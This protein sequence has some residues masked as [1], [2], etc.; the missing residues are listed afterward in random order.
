MPANPYGMPEVFDIVV[1][2]GGPA[3][4]TLAGLLAQKNRSVLVLERE[5]FPRYHIGES[6]IPGFMRAMEE[7]GLSE[8]LEARGF[9]KKGGG[10]LRW[11]AN[12]IPWA[13]RFNEGS[14]YKYSYHV[15]RADLDS[16]ILDR[17]RELGAKV[18]EEATV[19]DVIEEDGR[20]AGVTYVVR[21]SEV[22][23]HEA[24]A[25][26]VIDASGQARV[27][28]RKFTTVNWHEELRNVAVWTYFDNC[29]RL[30]GEEYSNILI[31]GLS[32]G[33]FWGI[34]IGKSTMSVGFVTTSET[35]AASGSLEDLFSARREGSTQLRELL[36]DARQAGGFRTARDW[37]YTCDRFCGPGWALVG[38]A[39]AFVDP[40]LSTGVALATLAAS[41][42]S[43][44]V[45]AILD[46]PG[47][48][49]EA[50]ERYAAA[51]LQFFDEI[52]VFVEKFYDQSKNKEFYWEQARK[53]IDPNAERGPRVAFA[54]LASGMSGG[55]PLLHIDIDDLIGAEAPVGARA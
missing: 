12:K 1:I 40:L 50:M 5:R 10:T 6:L 14:P 8:R 36:R 13:F 32:D 30:P 51:Y 16:M 23:L 33:W 20:V 22:P 48:E 15:R 43:G 7:L 44:V 54:S 37:S 31:E 34:P 25:S 42:L 49:D 38:D 17:A 18:L 53:I 47:I 28:G 2:G 55:H 46:N 19:K 9:E 11:G 4:A 29:D 21:G 52:R 41:A 39:A 24:R 26:M 27:L 3:G 35:A 45:D